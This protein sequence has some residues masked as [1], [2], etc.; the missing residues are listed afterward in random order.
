MNTYS[1]AVCRQWR[2]LVQILV[3]VM[4]PL[5]AMAQDNRLTDVE[6]ADGWTSL[7]D[8]TSMSHWRNFKSDGLSSNWVVEDGS[9]KLTGKDGGDIMT[10]KTYTN[11]DL[12][13]QWKISEA[14]N[15]GIFILVDEEG[16]HIY[17][18]APEIQIL[19][20]QRHSDN[21]IDSHLSG[22]LYDM[23]ASHPSSH[24]SAG[25]WNQVRV[26]FRNGFLQVWQ[27]EVAT[28]NITLGDS[29]WNTLLKGSKFSGGLSAMFGDFEGFGES[30]SGHIGLQDH[31]DPVAFKNIKIRELD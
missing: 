2:I 15:S 16:K 26:L 25:E 22:S 17:S 23:V 13:L 3:L 4:A 21:K 30:R 28:V 9:M 12:R 19:D 20:N 31:S 14:G 10:R 29:T 7:F 5:C 6:L 18:H 11:Y 8:G 24:K 1:E 27:N